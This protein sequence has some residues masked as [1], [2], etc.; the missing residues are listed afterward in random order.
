M[1]EVKRVGHFLVWVYK[2]E[3]RDIVA[4]SFI[5]LIVYFC[6]RTR[7]FSQYEWRNDVEAAVLCSKISGTINFGGS[8]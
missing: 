3:S 2:T 8:D 7:S 6:H 5:E 4:K 1:L